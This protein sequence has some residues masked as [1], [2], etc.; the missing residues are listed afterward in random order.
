MQYFIA[1]SL[2]VCLHR[3]FPGFY[4]WADVDEWIMQSGILS[5]ALF[6]ACWENGAGE[7][8]LKWGRTDRRGGGEKARN[9]NGARKQP[10]DRLTEGLT[11]APA[12]K[13][14]V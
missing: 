10:A 11:G 1:A 9:L 8:V 7:V 3:L 14:P 13:Q 6:G 4:V 5:P 12:Q 2:C